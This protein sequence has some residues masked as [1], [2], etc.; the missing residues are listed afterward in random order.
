MQHFSKKFERVGASPSF[1]EVSR[2]FCSSA[3]SRR[4][5]LSGLFLASS[6]ARP[7]QPAA[8]RDMCTNPRSSTIP[9][10]IVYASS[11]IIVKCGMCSGASACRKKVYGASSSYMS[12]MN[13][14]NFC[15]F[16]S[17]FKKISKCLAK[18]AK[19][20]RKIT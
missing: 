20:S 14:K 11:R 10:A 9:V 12:T 18:F 8:L 6:S 17:T 4:R 3:D 5:L 13:L 2:T 1:P 7:G 16:F 19:I 15:I